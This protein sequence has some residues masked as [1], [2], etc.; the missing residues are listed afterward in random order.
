[1]D[2]LRRFM[3][4]RNGSDQLCFALL[5]LSVVISVITSFLPYPFSIFRILCYLP[6]IFCLFRMF[7]KNLS[8]RHLENERFLIWWRNFKAKCKNLSA[9]LNRKVQRVKESKTHRF[10]KCPSCKQTLRLPKGR[11][12]IKIT[13]PK[14]GM[15]FERK[16]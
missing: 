15:N 9:A 2:W 4:G 3:Y 12:K 1:M 5:L 11:G 7:S 8:K 10:F 6:L 16:T 14:C 13:C